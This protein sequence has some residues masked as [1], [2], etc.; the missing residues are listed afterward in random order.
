M[1]HFWA[2]IAL[3]LAC[4]FLCE[5]LVSIIKLNAWN[6]AASLFLTFLA[7]AWLSGLIEEDNKHDI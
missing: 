3:F 5:T 2:L 1:R 6:A 4:L 7:A